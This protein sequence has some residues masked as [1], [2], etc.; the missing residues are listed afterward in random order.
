MA[1]PAPF[2]NL[3]RNVVLWMVNVV[4]DH[5]TVIT[6]PSNSVLGNAKTLAKQD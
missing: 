6:V 1:K 3:Q 5:S 4:F 2:Y